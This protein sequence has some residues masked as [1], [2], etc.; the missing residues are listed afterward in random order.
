[1]EIFRPA[2]GCVYVQLRLC[3]GCCNTGPCTM[4]NCL[5]QCYSL[6]IADAAMNEPFTH[7]NV[8]TLLAIWPLLTH[9]KYLLH[10]QFL[11]FAMR[12]LCA[13]LTMSPNGMERQRQN[14]LPTRS[15]LMNSKPAWTSL[16]M[17]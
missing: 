7:Y 17:I 10:H 13:G 11:Q 2:S 8:K 15:L 16:W 12:L 6:T 3:F 14:V 1:M 9:N 4:E 5:R